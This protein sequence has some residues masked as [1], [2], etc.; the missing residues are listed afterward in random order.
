MEPVQPLPPIV[1]DQPNGGVS[2]H[3]VIQTLTDDDAAYNTLAVK[4]NALVKH[5]K[6]YCS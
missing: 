3:K 4:H 1:A 5:V 6:E 2:E